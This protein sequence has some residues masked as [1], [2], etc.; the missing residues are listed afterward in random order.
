MARP[1]R[2]RRG[3]QGGAATLSRAGKVLRR[4]RHERQQ[5]CR[6]RTV[7][8][9]NLAV[10]LNLLRRCRDYLACGRHLPA[11]SQ[12]QGVRSHDLVQICRL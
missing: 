12:T 11:D 5:I 10:P 4:R 8:A 2:Y 6:L 9:K 7:G 1:A 3:R